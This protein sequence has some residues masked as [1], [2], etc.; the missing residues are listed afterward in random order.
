M[1]EGLIPV[2]GR[3]FGLINFIN[4]NAA[5]YEK[6][7]ARTRMML[8]SYLIIFPKIKE[9][10]DAALLQFIQLSLK[11]IDSLRL[12]GLYADITADGAD[13][14]SSLNIS[15]SLCV[16]TGEYFFTVIG[17]KS[18]GNPLR[19]IYGTVHRQRHPYP[20]FLTSSRDIFKYF[21]V[22]TQRCIFEY[23]FYDA[24]RTLDKIILLEYYLGTDV[25]ELNSYLVYGH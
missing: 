8:F 23:F 17:E 14:Q 10:T 9:H 2:R 19:V 11:I 3:A 22:L 20:S 21:F 25:P 4:T 24:M 16:W 18:G 5:A 12:P 13:V 1:S 15:T 7:A 6:V